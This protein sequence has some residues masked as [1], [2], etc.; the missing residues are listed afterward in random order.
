MTNDKWKY[1][2]LLLL[3]LRFAS[4]RLVNQAT[5][6]AVVILVNLF[7]A[8]RRLFAAEAGVLSQDD[9]AN[10]RLVARRETDEPGMVFILRPGLVS[11]CNLRCARLATY[12]EP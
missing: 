3:R 4:L 1:L 2:L 9:R 6:A 12:I 8:R 11:R 5:S 7:G 10:L